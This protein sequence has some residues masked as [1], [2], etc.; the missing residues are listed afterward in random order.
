MHG[1]HMKVLHLLFQY[2]L[3]IKRLL[4]THVTG[5]IVSFYTELE[6]K[7]GQTLVSHF[8]AYITASK[9]GLTEPEILD[10]LALDTEVG[11]TWSPCL[12]E[13]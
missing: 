2:P 8:L 10:I 9:H 11:N 4:D 6:D 7:Y 12:T 5:A 13:V 1:V 3:N